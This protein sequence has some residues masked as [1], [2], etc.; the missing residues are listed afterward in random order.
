MMALANSAAIDDFAQLDPHDI[1]LQ[2]DV[3]GTIIDIGP[4]P[5]EVHEPDE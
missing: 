4:S 2:H 5:Y 3:D 1:A